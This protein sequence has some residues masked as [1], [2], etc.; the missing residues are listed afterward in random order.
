MVNES[1]KDFVEHGHQPVPQLGEVFAVVE[2]I[3][4]APALLVGGYSNGLD[5]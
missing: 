2:V 3:G 5:G 4:H 1:L